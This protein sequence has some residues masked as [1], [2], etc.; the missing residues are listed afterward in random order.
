[1]L[2]EQYTSYV[3]ERTAELDRLRGERGLSYPW[4]QVRRLQDEVT[5]L[6]NLIA[7]NSHTLSRL[8]GPCPHLNPPRSALPPRA[9]ARTTSATSSWPACSTWWAT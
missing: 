5:E 2:E 8:V 1:M 4:E 6:Q 7:A 3:G 9:G